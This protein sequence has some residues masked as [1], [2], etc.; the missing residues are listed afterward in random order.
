[1]LFKQ[2]FLDLIKEKKISVAYRKWTRPTVKEN[3]TL[4]TPVGM[5]RIKSIEEIDASSISN[6]MLQ[7]AGYANPTELE[8]ELNLKKEGTVYKI[9]FTM[10]QEDPRIALRN[11]NDLSEDD[12]ETLTKKLQSLD[13]GGDIKN[14]TIKVLK[15][16]QANPAQR[17]IDLSAKLGYE[18]EW[19]KINV[20]KLKNL[21]LTISLETGYKISPRGEA[22]L[23]RL[24]K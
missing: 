2:K 8:K 24:K 12:L 15:A 21:G 19:F 16:I 7:Q 5:L 14:W 6:K 10:E 13:T 22:F 1:M 17:A 11:D 9:R 20:R 23:K 4:L 18:K 3:G